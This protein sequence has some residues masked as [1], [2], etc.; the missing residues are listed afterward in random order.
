MTRK[1]NFSYGCHS[2]SRS[3]LTSNKERN[4]RIMSYILRSIFLLCIILLLPAI[5]QSSDLTLERSLQENFKKSRVL[6]VKIER[7]LVSGESHV[8]N[9][10]EL[11]AL[12]ESI[13]TDHQTLLGKLR[14][15]GAQ[16]DSLGTRAV[17]R[18]AEMTAQY[19]QSLSQYL[20]ALDALDEQVSMEDILQL[21]SF[22]KDILPKRNR[23]IHGSI[24]YR[25]LNLPART[26]VSTPE[27]I[28]VYMGGNQSF[29]D[30][31]LAASPE[32][33]I[34]LAIAELAESLHW[35]PVEMYEWVKNNVETEWYWGAMKGA[36]ETLR[37]MSGNDADQATLLVALFRSA[38]FPARYV[39]G[40][41][42][43]FPDIE[44]AK[45]QV[46]LDGPMEIARFFQKAGIPYETAIA[47]GKISNFRIEH[48]WVEVEIPYDNYRGAVID[49][50]G[51][52]WLPLDTSI[53]AAGFTSNTPE[54]ALQ[55]LDLATIRGSYLADLKT[56]TPLEYLAAQISDQLN[57]NN[58]GIT[59]DD[60]RLS[61]SINPEH[62][63]IIPAAL[64][65]TEV[66]VTG[67]YF[68]LPDDL[69]H[70]ARF[71]AAKQDGTVLFDQ[72][73]PL[74]ELSNRS[75]AIAFEPET[76]EDQEIMNAYGGLDNTP[77]YLI[78]LR[79]ILTIDG[80]REIVGQ[81]GLT[82]GSDFQFGV[83]LIAPTATARVEN[84]LMAGYP[85]IIGLASQQAVIPDAVPL[86]DKNAERLLFE[87][88][89]SYIDQ[90]NRAEDELAS[91]FQL[92]IARPLP[93][94]VTLGGV[95]DI[96]YLL[97]SPHGYTWKG[98]YLDADLRVAEPVGG[99][100][101]ESG[102]SVSL[103]MQTSS[104]HGS[105]LE[106]RTFEDGFGVESVS[107]GKLFALASEGSIP[108][109]VINA[110][111]IDTVLPG[112]N[113]PES[114][115]EDITNAVNQGY[116]ITIPESELFYED[117]YG[118]AWIKENPITYESGWMLSGDIAGGM[119]AMNPDHLPADD[120]YVA[121]LSNPD[122]E[123]T[124]NPLS[125]VEIKVIKGPEKILIG[126]AG[127]QLNTPLQVV[128]LD[129]EGKRVEGVEV[130][131]NVKAGGGK[132]RGASSSGSWQSTV[133]V[134]TGFKGIAEIDFL[135][136]QSTNFNP[137]TAR[138][139]PGEA[140]QKVDETVIEVTATNGLLTTSPISVYGF[141]DEPHHLRVEGGNKSGSILSWEATLIAFVEDQY[142]NPINNQNVEFFMGNAQ[143]RSA[144]E[145]SNQDTRPGLLVSEN[146]HCMSTIPVY[147]EC[148]SDSVAGITGLHIG[149]AA[150]VIL[151]GLPDADY[152]VRVK[153]GTLAA[154]V[155]NIT[156]N[157]TGT[158][159][160]DDAPYSGLALKVIHASDAFGNIINGGAVGTTIPLYA[161]LYYVREQG[162]SVDFEFSCMPS[163]TDTCPVYTGTG[164]F[165]T[166][167]N[168]VNASVRFD[169]T[170]AVHIGNGL[171]KVDYPLHSEA[172][173]H[174]ISVGGEATETIKTTVDICHPDNACQ[175]V[176]IEKTSPPVT[177]GTE[178]YAVNVTVPREKH[179]IPVNEA[180]Y[181]TYDYPI[182]Y[183]IEPAEYQAGTAYFVLSKQIDKD[184]DEYENIAYF[185]SNATG[186]D[187][188]IFLRGFRFEPNA[189]YKAQVILNEGSE[190]LEVRSAEIELV[191]FTLELD[192]DLNRDGNF[193]EDDPRESMAPGLIVPL[194]FDDDDQDGVPDNID[195]Y[196]ADGIVNSDDAMTDANGV[197]VADNDL[198]EVKL[199]ALPASLSEGTVTLEIIQ[200][201]EKIK[202]WTDQ[203]KGAANLLIDGQTDPSG[204]SKTW[205]LGNDIVSISELPQSLYI[206]GFVPSSNNDESI[207]IVTKFSSPGAQVQEKEVDRVLLTVIQT[208]IVP[209]Y[210]RNNKIN[211]L[212]RNR[213]TEEKPWRFWVNTDNDDKS[214]PRIGIGKS[215]HDLPAVADKFGTDNQDDEVNGIRDL[216]DFFP[217][218]LD[219]SALLNFYAPLDEGYTYE[220]VQEDSAVSFVELIIPKVVTSLSDPYNFQ[221]QLDHSKSYLAL[222]INNPYD[223]LE[224][225]DISDA[226]GKS[227]LKVATPEGAELSQFF[228][229]K[230]KETPQYGIVLVEGIKQSTKPLRL[231]IKRYGFRHFSFS[232]PLVITNVEEMFSHKDLRMSLGEN[233]LYDTTDSLDLEGNFSYRY[234][235]RY[236][237]DSPP[238]LPEFVK[239][240]PDGS[241]NRKKLVMIHGFNVTAEAAAGAYAEAFKR[242]FHAGLDARFYGVGWYGN[243]PAPPFDKPPS[244]HYHQ[245]IV[246]AFATSKGYADFVKSLSGQVTL[247]AHSAGN[248]VA[249]VALQD[250]GV[251]QSPNFNGYIAMDAAVALEA[252]GDI[253]EPEDA[254]AEGIPPEKSWMYLVDNWFE[255]YVL[256]GEG[257]LLASE[258]YKLFRSDP[259]EVNSDD[260]RST[261]TWRNRLGSVPTY[262][263]FN[264]Y[265]STEDVLGNWD[266]DTMVGEIV[267]LEVLKLQ[268]ELRSSRF[269]WVKQEKFKGR[270]SELPVIPGLNLTDRNLS[271][272]GSP[273][274]G[275]GLPRSGEYT[276]EGPC[277]G[278]DGAIIPNCKIPKSAS[279]MELVPD[280]QLKSNPFFELED[281]TPSIAEILGDEIEASQFLKS[282]VS[283]TSLAS[284]YDDNVKANEIITVRDWLL[285]EAI[286]ATSFAM[287]SNENPILD[288]YDIFG[289][290]RNFDMSATMKTDEKKWPREK[291]IK[292]GNR[293]WRHSDY[294]D[295]PYQHVYRLYHEFKKINFN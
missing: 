61:R 1:S 213:V 240:N 16:L 244:S 86:D 264:Y 219:L 158:C 145:S 130:V 243:Q 193:S 232:F 284:Y 26:P 48:I 269:S 146:D 255:D 218:Y 70:K 237:D 111:N 259:D 110:A 98:A 28:P 282:K 203:T 222:T 51:K 60:L 149:A 225:L 249:S 261:L 216:V 250:H 167:T 265:S 78:H 40:V 174:E 69:L 64:Q 280:S 56:E 77:L 150:H 258:W 117:W 253:V 251:G 58:P 208:V 191:P 55:S 84:I 71:I 108:L 123:S 180:G 119:T 129:P 278:K 99:V 54:N 160:P 9:L 12:G 272:G 152:P 189:K 82:A 175:L 89:M 260:Y 281:G 10:T 131:F 235:D 195:G 262:K 30:D 201:A 172:S 159:D 224:N 41:I 246:G 22:I 6:L 90:G 101:M 43:F 66:A 234:F 125:A 2:E 289:V 122:V 226:Y 221:E 135:F 157:S 21:K 127:Q 18:H 15:R 200:G 88:A 276:V 47:G 83:E 181:V 11:K 267:D 241:E 285:A 57:V 194:N 291:E 75:I 252:Y 138:K 245:A 270:Y 50:H 153:S 231:E 4:F 277:I 35:N 169:G 76:I 287:G 238:N 7:A 274:M 182:E 13:R 128:A 14:N 170:E 42:E 202:I 147:G 124:D 126:T 229:S 5:A 184:K 121:R 62:M 52:T 8:S 155:V 32:A 107:T 190:F 236:L 197:L 242:F 294:R 45:D 173:K 37:Q 230:V 211:D 132:V 74:H 256:K 198:I 233:I 144:C 206:E 268:F 257:R 80:A 239:Y 46:G 286:P 96:V 283:D 53:K 247:L 63:K 248:M 68:S 79:P 141:P 133:T 279:D 161:R 142:G 223:Y 85:S 143:L 290:D 93:T 113:L 171:F 275:W 210:D 186:T 49:E 109:A 94:L 97:D 112:L 136:N 34:S 92:Q 183:S 38:G 36:E 139:E 204:T 106:N 185:N 151:G 25:H 288:L 44:S 73:M 91:L 156:S 205:V 114:I 20:H 295:M 215:K 212:D 103:F 104:L 39:R 154:E 81:N 273:Y 31:D 148:G 19:E 176:D 33:P 72:T 217:L 29:G 220:L 166:D 140:V 207:I 164:E 137:T 293:E 162:T 102:D 23:R 115:S 163:G 292:P 209:D 120:E 196:D 227:K 116:I 67:E 3:S 254:V 59:Y 100:P 228:L 17:S 199:R 179:F 263:V 266:G 192:G 27:I 214:D 177:H 87:R 165:F 168:F 105:I 24:P 118:Y 187:Q 188:M 65:F 178:V 134:T 271:G 95:L